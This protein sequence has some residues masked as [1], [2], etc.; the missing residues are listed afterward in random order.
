MKARNVGAFGFGF[1]LSMLSGLAMAQSAYDP[2]TT[3]VDFSAVGT[4]II[5]VGALVAAVL[6]TW[7]GVRMLLS[8]IRR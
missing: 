4:G 3:A 2:I 6:V 1:A 5:A 7:R 8:A